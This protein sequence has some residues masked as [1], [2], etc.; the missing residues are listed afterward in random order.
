MM[1]V[2]IC[3][4]KS[5]RDL[6]VAINAGADAV[7]FIT[8]VPVD[9]PRKITLSEASRLIAHVPLFVTSV[10][11][12]MPESADEAINMIHVAK[13]TA[14]QIHNSLPFEELKKIRETGVK[15]I[16][17]IPVSIHADADMLID[18]VKDLSGIADAVLLDTVL[19]GKTGGTGVTHNWELSSKVVLNAG[20]PVILAGGLSPE[21]VKAAVQCVRPHAVDTASGVET[22]GRKDEMKVIDFI[23]NARM[24]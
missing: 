18:L 2:K 7:G 16:K 9:S 4:I 12:I 1:K 14:A 24:T 20:L 17:T 6:A 21:N 3:G 15:L 8:E 10:L 22:D 23:N 19:D 5:E 11:V 13:P